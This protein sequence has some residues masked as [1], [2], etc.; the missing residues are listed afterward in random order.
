MGIHSNGLRTAPRPIRSALVKH[1][2]SQ[3]KE[4]EHGKLGRDKLK[5]FLAAP[6]NLPIDTDPFRYVY[7]EYWTDRQYLAE[8]LDGAP[9]L[10]AGSGHAEKP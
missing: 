4:S 5:A 10:P 9:V 8:A 2:A 1:H 6:H 7:S 3:F